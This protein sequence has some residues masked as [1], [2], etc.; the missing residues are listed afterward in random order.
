MRVR[1]R[2]ERQ[3]VITRTDPV[4]LRAAMDEAALCRPVGGADVMR[5]QLDHIAEKARE[6]HIRVQMIAFTAGAH[7]GMPGSF[8]LMNFSHRAEPEIIWVDSHAGDLFLEKQVEIARLRT[9]FDELI[10]QAL[11]PAQTLA[12]ITTLR[13]RIGASADGG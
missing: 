5:E 12:K 4:R 7:P 11:S 8:V 13:N 1:A 6:P 10:A 2:I 9:A 3:T